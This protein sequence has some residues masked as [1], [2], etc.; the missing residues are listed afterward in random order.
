MRILVIGKRNSVGAWYEYTCNAFRQGGHE[1]DSFA[2]NGDRF[3]D[4]VKYKFTKKNPETYNKFMLAVFQKK[5]QNKHYDLCVSLSSY[6]MPYFL[7]ELL[8]EKNP[9]CVLAGWVG[10]K[11]DKESADHA[12]LF[13]VIYYTDSQFLSDHERLGFKKNQ[14]YLPHAVEHRIFTEKTRQ[15]VPQLL[16]V[17]NRTDYRQKTIESIPREIKIIGRGWRNCRKS[18]HHRIDP[19]RVHFSKLN[20]IYD[21]YFCVLNIKNETH[22]FNGL[23]QRSF[24]P[25][26]CGTPVL[27]DDVTD[28]KK[29]FDPGEEIFVYSD[30]EQLNEILER[31]VA[32]P[33]IAARVGQAGKK[34]VCAEHTYRHR[35]ETML[36]DLG[37]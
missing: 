13:D 33:G 15:K 7:F 16:F 25:Y 8:R 4:H 23:N 36:H 17:A 21:K 29:C 5:I 9:S 19:N 24:E 14:K 3:L 18:S 27:H 35:I 30:T 2:I 12:N 26:G 37:A 34:R 28:L 6:W 11:F 10:D 22:V 32:D 20:R 31:I 1:V